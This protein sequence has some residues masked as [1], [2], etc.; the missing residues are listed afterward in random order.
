AHVNQI[1]KDSHD[2]LGLEVDIPVSDIVVYNEYVGGGYGWIDAGKAEAVKMLA[3]TEGMFID[4]V[5]T[6]TA[7]ACLID[8]CRKKV[9]KK[10]D[11]VLFLHTGG[12]VALF[13]YRGPLRAYS[14][15]KKLPWTI[16]DW[17]PQ[18]T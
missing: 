17:S 16:P 13:P 5:Y 1:I 14:E 11:N 8:L 12:A 2:V 7:M 10:R 3:E 18:S 4:P 9:F 6:A 15:G